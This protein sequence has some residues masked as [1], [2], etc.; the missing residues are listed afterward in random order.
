M[1][2]HLRSEA[3]RLLRNPHFWAVLSMFIVGAL[4]HY[5]QQT[6]NSDS[7][8][9]FSFIGL[10]R[11]AVERVYLLAPIA[12]ASF[13][14]H[15]RGGLLSLG[16]AS[17]I[18]FPR[19]VLISLDRADALFESAGVIVIGVVV[20]ILLSAYRKEKDYLAQALSQV[21]QVKHKLLVSKRRYQSLSELLSRIIDGSSVAFFVINKEHRVLYW[22]QAIEFLTNMSKEEIIGS[23]EHW[24]TFYSEKR[25]ALADLIVD[26]ASAKEIERYYQGKCQ[27]SSLIVG[28]YEAE[29][30]FP[31]LG[32]D[33]KWLHFTASPVRADDGETIGAIETLEDITERKRMEENVHYYI[34]QA[35]RAQEEERKRLARELH[36]EVAQSLLVLAQSL[37][38][39]S[40]AK[41]PRISNQALKQATE[42][43]HNQ[44]VSALEDIRRYAQDLRPRII[45]DLGLVAALEWLA[46]EL[47]KT[48][49]IDAHAEIIGNE[50]NLPTETQLV[51]FRIAQ[52]ALNNIRRHAQASKATIRLEFLDDR[53]EMTVSDNGK[54]F[55]V[56]KRLG[57]LTSLGKLG[58][59]GMRER[60]QLLKGELTIDSKVGRGTTLSL[61][62]PL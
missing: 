32:R 57:D 9:L 27:K 55:E 50:R 11:H 30:F 47:A 25:P 62:V 16:I 56:P 59:A 42:E 14:F 39:L 18:M 61:V 29:D 49:A 28:A 37:D 40:S 4:L 31:D 58:L 26:G 1:F 46:E 45:D 17:S 38:M 51:V 7:P 35:T 52:E 2:T 43:L 41:R 23:D 34:Q 13:F 48:Q 54:G 5:P 44:A 21:E 36:D 60:A 24:R 8:S 10:S 22:N 53:L 20:N 6:L 33:G 19:A 12:Y 3:A 15:T